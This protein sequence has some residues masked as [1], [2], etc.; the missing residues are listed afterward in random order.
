MGLC[1]V[2]C[3]TF[4]HTMIAVHVSCVCEGRSR[5]FGSPRFGLTALVSARNTI[6]TLAALVRQSSDFTYFLCFTSG[7][8]S[9]DEMIDNWDVSVVRPSTRT[10][11][12][13]VQV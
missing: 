4:L 13:G 8:P 11:T 6:S 2:D 9:Q 3:H 10:C 7:G 12:V 5:S 1:V